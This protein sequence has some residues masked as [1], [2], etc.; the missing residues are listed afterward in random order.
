MISNQKFYFTPNI[1]QSDNSIKEKRSVLLIENILLMHT[2]TYIDREDKKANIDGDI[3]LLDESLRP[4]GRIV[5]QVKTVNK[6]DEGLFRFPCP[7]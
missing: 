5:V 7:T 1:S 3:E 6:R 4:C 2:N